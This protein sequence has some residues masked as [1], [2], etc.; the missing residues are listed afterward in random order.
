MFSEFMQFLFSGL[1]IGSIY[2]LVALG[3][4]IIYNSSNI[5]NFAQGEFLMIG[6]MGTVMFMEAGLPMPIAAVAAVLLAV[7]AG[8]LLDKLAIERAGD[9]DVVPLIIITIGAALFIRGLAQYF[10]GKEFHAL[11]SFT[12]NEPLELFGATILPQ[13]L[14]V[15]GTALVL[16]CLMVW[17]FKGTLTGKA[18]LAVAANRDAAR[19]AGINPKFIL[20]LSFA[21]SAALSATAGIVAAPITL[22]SYNI[23]IMFALKGFVAAVLGGM[24]SAVGAVVGGL[25]LGIMEAMTAGYISSAYKD[26]VPFVLVLL[27]LFLMPSGLFGARATDRV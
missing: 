20:L 3:F 5:I 11:P 13:S 6:S 23:G 25:L 2:A 9:V 8:V 27:V 17:F 12:G 26:A 10:W 15:L 4:T 21:L 1:T 7:A 14:W 22:T 16:V 19:L 24:G 18:M